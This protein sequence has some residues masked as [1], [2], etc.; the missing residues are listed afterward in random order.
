MLHFALRTLHFALLES[1]RALL[2][3]RRHRLEADRRRRRASRHA[4]R[5]LAREGGRHADGRRAHSR[6]LPALRPRALLSLPERATAEGARHAQRF[7]DE[8]PVV[9][10]GLFFVGPPGIGKTHLAVAVLR[11]VIRTKGA[12]GHVLRHARFAEAD[13]QHLRSVDPDRGVAG[14]AARDGSRFARA[15]R[16]RRREDVRMGRGDAELHRQHALQRAARRRFSRPTTRRKPDEHGSASRCCSVSAFRMH[17]RLTR[18]ASSSRST[19]PTI[20]HAEPNGRPERAADA[21]EEPEAPK[22]KLPLPSSGGP[23]RAQ[24]REPRVERELKWPGGKAGYAEWR[25]AGQ[26][27]RAT[28]TTMTVSSAIRCTFSAH[29]STSYRPIVMLGLYLHIP[30]CSHICNYCNFNRGLFDADVK[31]QY[32]DALAAEI[33]RAGDGTPPTPSSSAAARPR[34]SIRRRSAGSSRRAATSFAVTPDAE[35]TLETNPETVTRRPD[36]RV[37][38]AGVNRISLGVQSLHD[39]ELARLGRQHGA[40]R[41]R[42]ASQTSARRASTTSASTSCCGCRSRRRPTGRRQSMD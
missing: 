16:S 19:A 32:V 4:V 21:V 24:L 17:S 26:T 40:A 29:R 8:F 33:A 23:I 1:V 9:D 37:S 15:R 30:F 11:Q 20:A 10:K 39:A 42:A 3:L 41:A 13:S 5:L 31:R 36:A 22:D 12:R 34:C 6:P 14:A 38:R 25:R 35:V 28:L 27:G 18:C 7:A 2:Y